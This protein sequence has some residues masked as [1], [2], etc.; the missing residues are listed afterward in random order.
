MKCIIKEALVFMG[1]CKSIGMATYWICCEVQGE[2]PCLKI[3]SSWA[4]YCA[5]KDTP[6]WVIQ[7]KEFFSVKSGEKVSLLTER[8]TRLLFQAWFSS[9]IALQMVTRVIS[10][11]FPLCKV[12][13]LKWVGLRE[14]FIWGDP[15]I[16]I[17]A[18]W[19]TKDTWFKPGQSESFAQEFKLGYTEIRSCKLRWMNSLLGFLLLKSQS[20]R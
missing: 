14:I 4:W 20:R 17:I 18:C 19:T 16:L 10:P 6:S 3:P 13:Q 8:K 15:V 1:I 7:T 12:L 11:A 5:Q 2:V 9:L